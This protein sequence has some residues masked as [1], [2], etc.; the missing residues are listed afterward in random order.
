MLRPTQAFYENCVITIIYLQLIKNIIP[1]G[2]M[3]I[4]QSTQLNA[5]IN[6]DLTYI[7]VTIH[8]RHTMESILVAVFSIEARDERK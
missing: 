2:M 8:L 4:A 6:V 7:D 3:Y 5:L 1:V